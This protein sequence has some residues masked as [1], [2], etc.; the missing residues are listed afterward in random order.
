MTDNRIYPQSKKKKK[1]FFVF[2]SFHHIRQLSVQARLP[3]WAAE[4]AAAP[5]SLGKLGHQVTSQ[6]PAPEPPLL[7]YDPHSTMRALCPASL[8]TKTGSKFSPSGALSAGGFMLPLIHDQRQV[9]LGNRAVGLSTFCSPADTCHRQ[10]DPHCHHCRPRRCCHNVP[11]RP[12]SV[13]LSFRDVETC[14]KCI[15]K[16]L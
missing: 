2:V 9:T 3:N 8:P 5:A 10:P 7:C 11:R 13:L 4:G 15:S 6:L 12:E 1:F 14:P 16:Q